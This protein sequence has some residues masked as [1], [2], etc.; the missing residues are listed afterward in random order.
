MDNDWKSQVKIRQAGQ[1]DL[2]GLEWEGEYTHFRQVYNE[3][4]KRVQRGLALIWI[5]ELPKKG[6]LGQ[7]LVQL[8]SDRTELAD[9]VT[10]A[11]IFAFRIRPSYRSHGLGTRLLWVIEADLKKRGY[12]WVTLNVARDNLRARALYERNGYIVVADEPGHWSFPDEK[13]I[14]HDVHEPAWRMEKRLSR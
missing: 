9:G 3:T 14:W 11:Y 1:D 7:A 5:L 2:A 13:G 12:S 10:R 4:Y 8:R 6:I